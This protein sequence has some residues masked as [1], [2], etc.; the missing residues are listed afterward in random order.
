[1][2]P[3]RPLSQIEVA[4]ALAA[5]VLRYARL[6]V[7]ERVAISAV[8]QDNRVTANCVRAAMRIV[9]RETAG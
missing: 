6:G 3:D 9:A 8:A 7:E 1:M 2:S 4:H 5:S